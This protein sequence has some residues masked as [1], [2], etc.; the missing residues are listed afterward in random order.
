MLEHAP[1]DHEETIQGVDDSLTY[2]RIASERA[3][4]EFAGGYG[5]VERFALLTD[6]SDVD[7]GG[8]IGQFGAW[9]AVR[10]WLGSEGLDVR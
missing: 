1:A 8:E 6:E 2:G 9:Y 10:A 5:K 3:H 4:A 7:D